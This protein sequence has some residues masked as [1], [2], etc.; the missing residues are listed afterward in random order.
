MASTM[1]L[2]NPAG[3]LTEEQV[4][5]H[6][7]SVPVYT[8]ATSNGLVVFSDRVEAEED[9]GPVALVFIN[10][11]DAEQFLSSNQN[12]DV[13]LPADSRVEL[14]SLGGMY[15]YAIS[16]QDPENPIEFEHIPSPDE[17]QSAV[18]VLQ[19]QLE[20]QGE[21]PSEVNRFLGVPLFFACRGDN[22]CFT[23]FFF[24]FDEFQSEFQSFVD[25]VSEENSQ[26][27]QE[28]EPS[29]IS[30]ESYIRLL[31]EETE[32]VEDLAQFRLVPSIETRQEVQERVQA[33]ESE[34]EDSGAQ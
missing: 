34:A 32:D 17:R 5:D 16:V 24:S 15:E 28:L 25:R 31:L 23:T 2:I 7:R 27:A 8:I 9:T 11:D 33:A 3:A 12:S 18:E 4:I 14:G 20:R 22:N 19:D 1:G 10:R 30:L 29:V 21:D 6:L 13:N 26:V